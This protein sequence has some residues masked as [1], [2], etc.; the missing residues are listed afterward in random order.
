MAIVSLKDT[1][2]NV[3][4]FK[5]AKK[6]E[7]KSI[8]VTAFEA[9]KRDS[10][11]GAC[12]KYSDFSSF[13]HFFANVE[14]AKKYAY[15]IASQCEKDNE[16]IFIDEEARDENDYIV[17]NENIDYID[18]LPQRVE[19]A[20]KSQFEALKKMLYAI[21]DDCIDKNFSHIKLAAMQSIIAHIR[22]DYTYQN[23]LD[24]DLI[25]LQFIVDEIDF[26]EAEYVDADDVGNYLKHICNIRD[27]DHIDEYGYIA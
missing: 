22:S 8:I 12:V 15:G 17:S 10:L 25:N 6:M 5:E 11:T 26:S 23:I 14:E 7:K 13:Q 9:L 1:F 16:V 2:Y 18:N 27:I 19:E 20:E 4:D 21:V 24:N 3:G